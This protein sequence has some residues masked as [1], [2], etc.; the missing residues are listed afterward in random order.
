MEGGWWMLEFQAKSF[1]FFIFVCLDLD[2]KYW[3]VDVSPHRLHCVCTC[4]LVHASKITPPLWDHVSRPES[5]RAIPVHKTCP[6]GRLGR[7][8]RPFLKL[9]SDAFGFAWSGMRLWRGN[10]RGQAPL[11]R[12]RKHLET[13]GGNRHSAFL[14]V[15]EDSSCGIVFAASQV[16][17]CSACARFHVWPVKRRVLTTTLRIYLLSWARWIISYTNLWLNPSIS[18]ILL[19]RLVKK[20]QQSSVEAF[21][22]MNHWWEELDGISS[23][24]SKG[25][26]RRP[27]WNILPVRPMSACVT[28]FW[29]AYVQKKLQLWQNQCK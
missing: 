12:M 10:N 6:A 18:P 4:L 26:T 9:I 16:C 1:L 24:N 2:I 5:P 11:W 14:G 19:L 21:M 27:L 13:D 8:R 7:V 25:S 3:R 20:P 29:C 17:S 23:G 28:P 15:S 22:L